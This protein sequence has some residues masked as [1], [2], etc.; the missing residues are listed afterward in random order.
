MRSTAYGR[1]ALTGLILAGGL[2]LTASA[3]AIPDPAAEAPFLA[4]NQVAMDKMMAEMAIKP[5]GDVDRDFSAM[6]TQSAS[7]TRRPLRG[8]PS[9]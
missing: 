6:M 3:D 9:S 8:T 7:G 2:A 4:E 1:I 5:S